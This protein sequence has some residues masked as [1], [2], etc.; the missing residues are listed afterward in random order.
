MPDSG[1]WGVGKRGT[2]GEEKARRR[3]QG[4]APRRMTAAA[5]ASA[6]LKY[7]PL[8]ASSRRMTTRGGG[9]RPPVG[10]RRGGTPRGSGSLRVFPRPAAV[11]RAEGGAQM[12][13]LSLE[14]E[15]HRLLLRHVPRIVRVAGPREH[16]VVR[17]AQ[18]PLL[19]AAASPPADEAGS[20][21]HLHRLPAGTIQ[22]RDLILHRPVNLR[23]R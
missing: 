8:G 1:G 4:V 5:A 13:P 10:R 23:V 6:P 20:V 3:G 2:P 22:C 19:T 14:G 15:P 12:R 9:G 17:G 18:R 11:H 21:H 7:Q 16:F